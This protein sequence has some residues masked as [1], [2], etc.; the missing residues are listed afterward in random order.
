MQKKKKMMTKRM[1]RS[2]IKKCVGIAIEGLFIITSDG[3]L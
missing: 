3:G 1:S 2:G